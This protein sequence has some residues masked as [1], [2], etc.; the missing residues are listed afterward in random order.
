MAATKQ[1]W[2]AYAG[3]S[4]ALRKLTVSPADSELRMQMAEALFEAGC[5]YGRAA[6]HGARND[7]TGYRREAALALAQQ[8]NM[9]KALDGLADAGYELP[10]RA[11]TFP[12]L[13]SLV[14]AA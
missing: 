6:A 4:K 2:W 9:T 1:V 7:R 8:T 11:A 12:R 3:A 5:A 10:S 14:A 13:P